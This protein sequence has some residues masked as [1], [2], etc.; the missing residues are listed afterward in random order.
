M[1]DIMMCMASGCPKSKLC[2]RHSD[3]GTR[4]S[5]YMQAFWLRE[6]DS[7]IGDACPNFWRS[8]SAEASIQGE[9]PNV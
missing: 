1:P 7:P 2:R 6:D 3:S 4:A 8:A 5:E 9:K